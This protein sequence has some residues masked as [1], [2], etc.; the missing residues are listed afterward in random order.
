MARK[1]LTSVF[2]IKPKVASA[3]AYLP[4]LKGVQPVAFKLARAEVDRILASAKI[5]KR[6]LARAGGAEVIHHGR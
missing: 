3:V 1:R 5:R 4:T 6:W 2:C